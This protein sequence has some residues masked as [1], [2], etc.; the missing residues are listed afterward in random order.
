MGKYNTYADAGTLLSTD[1]LGIS[2]SPFTA[3]TFFTTTP[4]KIAAFTNPWVIVSGTSQPMAV[5]TSY[6]TTNASLTTFTLPGTAAAGTTLRVVGYGTGGWKIA[7]NA[8]QTIHYGSL[9]STAGTGGHLDSQFK[10][11]SV[12]LVCV[13]ANTDFV[14]ASSQNNISIT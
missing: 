2:R 6:V 8:G 5:N 13:V 9:S 12:L 11:D 10:T 3:G 14:V 4:T 7:Q 1:L